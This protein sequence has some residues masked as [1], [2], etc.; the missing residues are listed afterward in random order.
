MKAST[1][2]SQ[3]QFTLV[4]FVHIALLIV[5]PLIYL[6]VACLVGENTVAREDF[7]PFVLYLLLIV[8]MVQPALCPVIE[9][10]QTAGHRTEQL[11][12][13]TAAGLYVSSSVIRIAFVE[14]V[15]I[16]GLI[17]FLLSGE[18]VNMLYFYPVGIV[19]T[20]I[21]WPR[22]MRLDRFLG[23]VRRR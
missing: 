22:R 20:V 14:A 23:L 16:Y 5:A 9:K 8:G 18:L 7:G 19:W 4:R 13:K 6:V 15:Y 21:Y 3:N 12:V 10:M 1:E 17:A 11:A 2:T